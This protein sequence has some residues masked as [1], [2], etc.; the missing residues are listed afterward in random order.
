MTLDDLIAAW[1]A[2][3]EI[4]LPYFGGAQVSLFFDDEDHLREMGPAVL[5]FLRL[6]TAERD[7]ASVHAYSYFRDFADDVGF[8]DGWIDKRMQAIHSP[9]P[10]IWDFVYPTEITASR[11]DELGERGGKRI[12]VQ[13]WANCGWEEEHGLEMSFRDGDELVK[14]SA[15]DGHATNGHAFADPTKDA[16]VY[17]AVSPAWHTPSPYYF[18]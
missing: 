8:E 12:Y 16:F 14:L 10:E 9:G 2:G 13:V 5:S 1:K 18:V 7:A 17:V 6:T 3:S 4:Q 15:S 11:S